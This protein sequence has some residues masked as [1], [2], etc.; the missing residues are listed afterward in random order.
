MEAAGQGL[1]EW[2]PTAPLPGGPAVEGP[3]SPRHPGGLS[4]PRLRGS[5]PGSQCHR[6][7]PGEAPHGAGRCR[8]ARG[9]VKTQ[10][11]PEVEGPAPFR[12]PIPWAVGPRP[13]KAFGVFSVGGCLP[14]DPEWRPSGGRRGRVT[15]HGPPSQLHPLVPAPGLRQAGGIRWAAGGLG[16]QL[17]RPP[18][19][20]PALLPAAAPAPPSASPSSR[21]RRTPAPPLPLALPGH[22]PWGAAGQGT[23]GPRPGPPRE[24]HGRVREPGGR[25]PLGPRHPQPGRRAMPLRPGTRGLL[26]PGS[27]VPST[28]PP[29]V[30]GP[31]A[32]R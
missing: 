9:L 17:L 15:G 4:L 26:S 20:T 32:L 31:L 11:W 21:R 16:G 7:P 24:A 14:G 18:G 6:V 25:R 2:H 30:S 27:P 10:P 3:L 12:G 13:R 8:C 1:G 29:V 28:W 23:G 19:L 22:P 5:S